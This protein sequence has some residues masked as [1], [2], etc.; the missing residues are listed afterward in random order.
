[1]GGAVDV[2]PFPF[3]NLPKVSRQELR[4]VE[5]LRS[6]WPRIGFSDQLRRSVK[7][8]LM[9]ELGS[10]FSFKQEKIS[11]VS[12]LQTFKNLSPEG[13][14]ITFGRLPL[15]QKAV[16]DLD[17]YLAHMMIDKLFGGTGEVPA[18][19]R[20]LTEIESGVLS[21]LALKIFSLIFEKCG[22]S[23]RVHLRLDGIQ[24]SADRIV[25]SSSH[26]EKGVEM[27]F[28]VSMNKRAGYARLILPSPFIDEAK[29]D[30]MHDA[31]VA[32]FT[33]RDSEY[34]A[35]RL[36]NFEFLETDLWVELG[37]TN[38]KAHEV[39]G[40]ESGDVILLEKTQ[41]RLEEGKLAGQLSMRMGK[42][43]KGAFRGTIV[44][45]EGPIRV[46]LDG[47]ELEHPIS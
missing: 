31:S 3:E 28:R 10:S 5:A 42:G 36:S 32:E 6:Y 46:F 12:L 34:Y 24:S 2:K 13:V 41:A 40:L 37:R 43:E 14:Y 25:E 26:G 39:N 18:S 19:S 1:M 17:P 4:I 22:R 33:E 8:L 35:A 23:A 27:M 11:V 15:P 38:L 30:P 16:L 9:R 20:S 7:S 45:G 29:L 21:Y 47:V 44:S